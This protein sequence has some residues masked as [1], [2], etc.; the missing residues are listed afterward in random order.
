MTEPAPDAATAARR[1]A[2]VAHLSREERVLVLVRDELFAGVWDDL[3]RDLRARLERRPSIFKLSTRIEED[4]ERIT[5]LRDF[6]RAEGV[7]LRS[8]LD[9]IP[10][11]GG[12][13]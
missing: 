3:E 2:F 7:D 4:L 10:G 6:E 9:P 12:E 11:R 5:K 13:S 1:Q 8:L